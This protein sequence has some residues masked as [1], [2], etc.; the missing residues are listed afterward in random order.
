MC[1]PV[2]NVP[3]SFMSWQWMFSF[4]TSNVIM[5]LHLL[6]KDDYKKETLCS[7]LAG[8]KTPLQSQDK[9]SLVILEMMGK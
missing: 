5:S 4:L 6:M 2:E 3:H 7:W 8:K 1:P 9:V